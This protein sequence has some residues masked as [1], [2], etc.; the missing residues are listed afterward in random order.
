M[1]S[2]ARQRVKRLKFKPTLI[3]RSI[4]RREGLAWSSSTA[5]RSEEAVLKWLPRGSLLW[6]QHMQKVIAALG[7]CPAPGR[8]LS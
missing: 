2:S 4:P 5:L 6:C 3:E 8:M 7:S 1:Q